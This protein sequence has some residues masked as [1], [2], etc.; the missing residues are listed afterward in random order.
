VLSTL[1]RGVR[2]HVQPVCVGLD[3]NYV[4]VCV[5]LCLFGFRVEGFS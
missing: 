5:S 4:L 2:A 3:Q 1:G